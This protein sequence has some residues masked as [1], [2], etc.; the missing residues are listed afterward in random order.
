[1][2]QVQLSK[3][4]NSFFTCTF[5]NNAGL[6]LFPFRKYFMKNFHKKTAIQI[7]IMDGKVCL[8]CKGKTIQGVFNKLLRTKKF[9]V[10]AQQGFALLPQVNFPANNL[11]FH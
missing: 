10:I 4:L 5:K 1:M 11:N 8:R 9:G 2:A 6:I 7:Q 3:E